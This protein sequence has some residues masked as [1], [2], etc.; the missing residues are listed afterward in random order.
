MWVFVKASRL[1]DVRTGSYE[2][3]VGIWTENDRVKQ[4][5]RAAELTPLVPKD[6][7]VIDLGQFTILPGLVDCHTHVML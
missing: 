1:L 2:E 5:G 3:N 4:V 7:K 6:A